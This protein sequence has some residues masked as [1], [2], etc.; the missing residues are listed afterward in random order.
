M[1]RERAEGGQKEAKALSRETKIGQQYYTLR[2]TA[3]TIFGLK[4][5]KVLVPFYTYIAFPR[6]WC[7]GAEGLA[8]GSPSLK[9]ETLP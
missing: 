9:E 2:T 3:T 7:F 5:K 4:F 6:K 1:E 8:Y